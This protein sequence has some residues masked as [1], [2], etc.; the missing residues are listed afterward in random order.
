MESGIKD[1]L[2]RAKNAAA[3]PSGTAADIMRL[4]DVRSLFKGVF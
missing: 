3:E 2:L 1:F 4:L